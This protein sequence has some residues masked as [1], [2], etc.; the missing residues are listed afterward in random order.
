MQNLIDLFKFPSAAFRPKA[1]WGLNDR[2]KEDELVRQIREFALAGL[3]GFVLHARPGLVTPFLGDEWFKMIGVCL[4]EAERLGLEAWIYDDDRWP[5]GHA[6][7]KVVAAEPGVAMTLLHYVYLLPGEPGPE[8]ALATFDIPPCETCGLAH[9]AT[10]YKVAFTVVESPPLAWLNGAPPVTLHDPRTFDRFREIA[11][12]PY[13][14]LFGDRFGRTIRGVYTDEP[15]ARPRRPA[16]LPWPPGFATAF[17]EAKGYDLVPEL[18]SLLF[19][20]GEWK[21]VR[22]DYWDLVNALYLESFLVPYSEWCERHGLELTGHFEAHEFPGP[23]VQ[24]APMP[25]Q[26]WMQRPG[27]D[28][29]FNRLD[30]RPAAAPLDVTQL[31]QS[32]IVREAA[33]VAAQTGRPRVMCEAYGGS[34]WEI[35]FADLK[36]N[37]DWLLVQGVNDLCLH[38]SLYSLRGLRKTDYPPSFREHEPWWGQYRLLSDRFARLSAVLSHGETRHRIAV[39]HPATTIW[40]LYSPT[41]AGQGEVRQLAAR[42]EKLTRTLL[43]YHFGFDL[44]HESG[45]REE[46]RVEGGLLAVG[47]GRYHTLIIPDGTRNLSVHTFRI[48]REFMGQGGRVVRFA[49]APELVDGEPSPDLVRMME[50]PEVLRAWDDPRSIEY[51]LESVER[52]DVSIRAQG[53]EIVDVFCHQRT[54]KN[55]TFYFIV[56]THAAQAWNAEI[57]LGN[58]YDVEE[59]DPADGSIRV[60]S[61]RSAWGPITVE[62]PLEPA[63]SRLLAV[64]HEP[65]TAALVEPPATALAGTIQIEHLA[66]RRT[67][68][69]VLVLDVCRLRL[70]EDGP[71]QGPMAASQA[72]ARIYA[73]HDLDVGYDRPQPWTWMDP[74][75]E[76]RPGMGFDLEFAFSVAEGFRPDRLHLVAESGSLYAVTVNG[77]AVRPDGSWWLDRS[78][79]RF[80]IA[81]SIRDGLNSVRL[82]LRPMRES[83]EP[84]A[85]MLV[86]DFAVDRMEVLSGSEASER[87][88]RYAARRIRFD[89]VPGIAPPRPL[90]LGDWIGHGLPFYSGS[91]VYEGGFNLDSAEN[92]RFELALRGWRGVLCSVS[93]NGAQ[94]GSIAWPPYRLDVT[95]HV[96]PGRNT[97]AVR[98]YSSLRNALGPRHW[99]ECTGLVRPE[100]FRTQ[101]S[102]QYL[103]P[104]EYLVLE[105]GLFSSPVI[106][107]FE[108]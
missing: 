69:N 36:R 9:D 20:V 77:E 15:S 39:L 98:L 13:A 59:W 32:R 47:H 46:A 7:G 101:E 18:P 100:M 30:E 89:A 3:G 78:F 73:S 10:F 19:E 90:G 12:E 56:N 5:S 29:L 43:G 106:E 28:C 54:F 97:L 84:E 74:A 91:V 87:R 48:L 64:T 96:R 70:D 72:A 8:G 44:V 14:R 11:L 107:V 4:D 6:G 49:D 42:F 26:E 38:A 17:R 51:V 81:G 41:G 104:T 24:E 23:L 53:R 57:V 76:V 79:E 34:G 22:Y 80:P 105:Q 68:A 86:G 58:G 25:C 1:F 55:R 50:Y 92:R 66:G 108:P 103:P 93:V 31:G 83:I 71:W 94:V 88:S 85:C 99:P 67:D 52:R 63:G 21:R 35:D 102:P 65:S 33:S 40:T 2:L 62:L 61:G 45:L 60:I 37:A 27:I 75:H 82:S 16:C 95:A